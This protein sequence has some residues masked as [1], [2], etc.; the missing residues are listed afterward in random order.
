MRNNKSTVLGVIGGSGVYQIEGIDLIKEHTVDT[1]FGKPSDAVI[2]ANLDGKTMFF[3][4]RHGRGHRYLPTEVNYRAN[5]HALKQF[6]VTHLLAVSAVGIMRES[7][8]P[9]DM[10]VP[11][12][13]FDRTKGIRPSTFFGDGVVGH[14]EFADPFSSE[15]RNLILESARKETSRVHDGGALIVME[16]PQFSTRAESNFYRK[17]LDP[18]CIGMTAL[19]E[20]KLAREAEM[21]Y[22]LL[23]MATDY[24]CW[25]E[26]SD[27]V[28]V[29]A[30]V[31]VLKANASV[32]S[33]IVKNL[34]LSLPE[35]SNDP[36]LFAAKHAVMTDPAVIP[37]EAKEKLALLYG[38]YFG[39]QL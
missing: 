15:M 18:S 34:A 13:L 25:N 16:G 23:A 6:G 35:L 22:G 14:I 4:P 3:L 33:S 28:S 38:E 39:S 11:D 19:P 24:D 21:A 27:D 20:A 32:A 26:H 12:Q 37:A 36:S 30:V 10:I 31:A 5:I 2:E 7:I 29:E 1:P 9:G 17:T 8:N